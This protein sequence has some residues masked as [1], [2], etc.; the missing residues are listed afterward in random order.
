VSQENVEL[1]RSINA[2]MVTGDVKGVIELYHEDAEWRDL[3]H[4]PDT[5]EAVRG[6]A[7]ILALWAHWAELFDEIRAEVFEYIDAQPW[8]RL[9]HPVVR[10]RQRERRNDRGPGR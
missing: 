4:A 9:R 3:Q 2:L 8:G 1:V 5:A 7:A 10:P 6:R